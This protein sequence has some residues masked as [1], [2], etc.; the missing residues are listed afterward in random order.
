MTYATLLVFGCVALVVWFAVISSWPRFFMMVF[1]RAVLRQGGADGPIPINTMYTEPEDFFSAPLDPHPTASRLF[2]TGVNHDTLATVAVLDLRRGPLVLHV[3]DMAERYYS[4]QFTN[5]SNNT[6]FAYVG[7]RATGNRA[8]AH[9][10]TGPGWTGTV[11]PGM[12][13]ISSPVA[14]VLVIGR[15]LVT[16]DGDLPIAH[17]LAE[18]MH[19]APSSE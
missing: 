15:T 14:S 9:L 1:T 2:T 11:P 13:H 16:D 3:P 12:G 19:L 6:A 10:I 17:Q 4:V 5:A 18:S 7:T 8:G